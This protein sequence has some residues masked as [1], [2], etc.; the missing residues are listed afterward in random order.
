MKLLGESLEESPPRQ[1]RGS[2]PG[3]MSANSTGDLDLEKKTAIVAA[4]AT[5]KSTSSLDSFSRAS[6][7]SSVGSPHTS[8][9]EITQDNLVAE[10]LNGAVRSF[11]D[12]SGIASLSD[13]AIMTPYEEQVRLCAY[14]Y[15][16]L[17]V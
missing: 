4:N 10:G 12:S 6:G 3:N 13:N 14:A 7:G 16:H 5:V 15:A 2:S 8:N 17:H 1:T 11:S 9:L